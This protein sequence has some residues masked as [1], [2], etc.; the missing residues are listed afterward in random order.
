MFR[1]S[2]RRLAYSV[3]PSLKVEPLAAAAAPSGSEVSLTMLAAPVT[4]GDLS[5]GKGPAGLEGAGLVTAVG[6]SVSGVAV[7][8]VV[9]VKSGKGTFR[10]FLNVPQSDVFKI[11]EGLP[12]AYAAL[13]GTVAAQA[14]RILS[15]F[16]PEGG[17]IV[18][19][20]AE[21][22][23]GV[24]L[25]QLARA[26]GLTTVNVLSEGLMDAE[27]AAQL[28]SAVAGEDSVVCDAAYLGTPAFKRLAE[29]LGPVMLGVDAVG[30]GRH[31]AKMVQAME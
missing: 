24:A 7:G 2:L 10:S 15:D 13:A 23:V 30:A 27:D 12:P 20:C 5:G 16:G 9:Q 18:Q 8:D 3:S 26:K 21:Q 25:A 28:V 6:S 29:G 1:R 31:S 4:R 17:V 22:P 19:N 14:L 11:P